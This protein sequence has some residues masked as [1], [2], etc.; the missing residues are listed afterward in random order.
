MGLDKTWETGLDKTTWEI[1]ENPGDKY[2]YTMISLYKSGFPGLSRIS[3]VI[4]QVVFQVVFQ[5]NISKFSMLLRVYLT[6]GISQS[7][8]SMANSRRGPIR[9]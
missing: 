7:A 2:I 5:G 1:L 3:Q 9:S 4:S 8:N 6:P